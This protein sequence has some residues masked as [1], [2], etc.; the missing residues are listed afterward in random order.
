MD[1]WWM[2]RSS[3]H[4]NTLLV[5]KGARDNALG[6][7]RGGFSTK[8]HALVDTLGKPLHIELTGGQRHEA[9]VAEQLI[10][11]ARGTYFLADTAYDGE[12][13]RQALNAR[14]MEAVI[15]PHPSRST[16]PEY[17]KL[18]YKERHPRLREG[19]FF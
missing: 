3:E 13:I 2:H 4:T 10:D 17:D 19:R 6:K 5:E 11:H 9:S 18:L 7:S 8:I 1:R 14:G 16:A 15:R 12:R